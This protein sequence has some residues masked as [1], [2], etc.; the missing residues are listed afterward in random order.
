MKREADRSSDV[1][2]DIAGARSS[3]RLGIGIGSF[4]GRMVD[5]LFGFDFFISYSHADGKQYPARLTSELEK[6]GLRTFLDTQVYVP[7]DDLSRATRR[8]VRMSKYLVV[9]ARPSALDSPWVLKEVQV[10]LESGVKVIVVNVNDAFASAGVD[11][12]LKRLLGDHLRVD[13]RT[14][15]TDGEPTNHVMGELIRSFKATRRDVV[16]SRTV[17]AVAAVLF[18]SVLVASAMFWRAEVARGVAKAR[19]IE[20]ERLLAES[21]IDKGGDEVNAGNYAQAVAWFY[22]AYANA[23]SSDHEPWPSIARDLIGSWS[24]VLYQ[25]LMHDA[26]IDL[27]VFSQDGRTIYTAGRSKHGEETRCEIQRW[28]AATGARIADPL[29]DNELMQDT[30]KSLTISQNGQWLF[31]QMGDGAHLWDVEA[32]ATVKQLNVAEKFQEAIAASFTADG[33]ITTLTWDGRLHTWES[34]T[35][36]MIKEVHLVNR[37]NWYFK[38]HR[39]TMS[40]NGKTVLTVDDMG[41]PQVW[42]VKAAKL[43]AELPTSVEDE[44]QHE[45]FVAISPNGEQVVLG[46]RGELLHLWDVTEKAKLAEFEYA[47]FVLFGPI[48]KKLLV[49]Y[50]DDKQPELYRAETGEKCGELLEPETVFAGTFSP[51]EET[52]VTVSGRR[53]DGGTARMWDV[54]RGGSLLETLKHIN[55]SSVAF[56]PL[57]QLLLTGRRRPEQAPSRALSMRLPPSPADIPAR[58]WNTNTGTLRGD[59]KADQDVHSVIFDDPEKL[60]VDSKNVEVLSRLWATAVNPEDGSVVRNFAFSPDGTRAITSHWGNGAQLWITA[61]GRL[62]RPPLKHTLGSLRLISF[63]PD[64][65]V[66]TGSDLLDESNTPHRELRFWCS[67]SGEPIGEPV[68]QT[69]S[70]ADV[71][72]SPDGSALI[73]RSYGAEFQLWEIRNAT[74]RFQKNHGAFITSVAFGPDGI[75]A[76][77]GKDGKIRLWRAATGEAYGITL[78]HEFSIESIIFSPDGETIATVDSAENAK[79]WDSATSQQCGQTMKGVRT[80]A[81]KHDSSTI[82]TANMFDWRIWNV[83]TGQP[84]GL[85]RAHGGDIDCMVAFSSDGNS[86]VTASYHRKDAKCTARIWEAPKPAQED[87][88]RLGL[89]VG[90]RTGYYFAKDADL[91]RLPQSEWLRQK[92]RLRK[93]GG[94]CDFPQADFVRD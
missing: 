53:E 79:L 44:F 88:K 70:I 39:A 68:R 5:F 30:F 29:R 92:E 75:I 38:S 91:R 72:F 78:E 2:S 1:K 27:V 49:A 46:N 17:T 8:R 22:A 43:I 36:E 14:D 40:S 25:S 33:Q 85:P 34:A 45:L 41:T 37:G 77:G 47:E 94:P 50:S 62:V 16:R 10:C 86:I 73:M 57:S 21:Y 20:A 81:F 54:E 35:G 74:Q 6:A 59:A 66:V 32:N 82:V 31:A 56:S 3:F 24:K 13:E 84:L 80:V 18:V 64:G 93:L 28:D 7:G 61:N 23:N 65:T 51:D 19:R 90:V 26:E 69:G 71:A 12:A 15:E 76:T 11:N 42:D 83:L 4:L 89:S 9:I 58:M 63:C 60:K 67:E 55:V 52:V 48:G 87:P